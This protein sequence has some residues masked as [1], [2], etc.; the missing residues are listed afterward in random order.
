[1][2]G[3]AGEFFKKAMYGRMIHLISRSRGCSMK[4]LADHCEVDSATVKRAVKTL[5][6]VYEAPISSD[7]A[8]YHWRPAPHER[9]RAEALI[10]VFCEPIL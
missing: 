1:M 5:R 9:K 6:E 4:S 8:G 10:T 7:R 3:R 2:G